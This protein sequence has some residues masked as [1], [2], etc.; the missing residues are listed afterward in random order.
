MV[1][2]A[3]LAFEVAD[4]L[5]NVGEGGQLLATGIGNALKIGYVFF[6]ALVAQEEHLHEWGNTGAA[7]GVLGRKPVQKFGTAAFSDG[8]DVLV[9]FFSLLDGGDGCPVVC[10][11]GVRF[12]VGLAALRLPEEVQGLVEDLSGLIAG[13]VAAIRKAKYPMFQHCRLCIGGGLGRKCFLLG[14]RGVSY[15]LNDIPQGDCLKQKID[16]C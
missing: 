10:L 11:E 4:A 13:H 8:T 12:A 1:L 6:L 14:V 16:W 15:K 3:K 2:W 5:V 9:G 7:H